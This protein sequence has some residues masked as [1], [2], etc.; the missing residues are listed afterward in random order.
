M[1]LTAC[2]AHTGEMDDL[3]PSRGAL[4]PGRVPRRVVTGAAV[5]VLV[6]LTALVGGG[7]ADA[8]PRPSTLTVTE[9]RATA[10]T[11]LRLTPPTVTRA[12][13]TRMGSCTAAMMDS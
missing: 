6:G 10:T 12:V 7:A 3:Q 5:G 9:T 13:P 1:D 4:R 11:P 2:R 8:A